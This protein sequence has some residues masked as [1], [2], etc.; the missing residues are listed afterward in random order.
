M[1][2]KQGYDMVPFTV[3]FHRFLETIYGY[4][5]VSGGSMY[6]YKYTHTAIHIYQ[7]I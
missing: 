2:K 3:Y 1:G 7:T 6:A 4:N 5:F